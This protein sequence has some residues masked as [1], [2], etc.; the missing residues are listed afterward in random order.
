MALR[1][2][3]W[4]CGRLLKFRF[5]IP[6]G[7]WMPSLESFVCVKVEVSAMGRSLVQSRLNECVCVNV[8]RCNSNPPRLR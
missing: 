2:R 8:I 1:S 5:P 6:L 7:A 3:P 4:M